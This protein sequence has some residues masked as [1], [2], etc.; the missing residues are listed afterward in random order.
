MTGVEKSKKSL[1]R[2]FQTKA[3][4]VFHGVAELVTDAVPS[5]PR[6]SI[7]NEKISTFDQDANTDPVKRFVDEQ[8]NLKCDA[9]HIHKKFSKK[10]KN[11]KGS[12]SPEFTYTA[13]HNVTNISYSN[14]VHIGPTLNQEF[15]TCDH[16]KVSENHGNEK[17]YRPPVVLTDEIRCLFVD[18]TPCTKDHIL[19]LESHI[20]K[21]WKSLGLSLKFSPGQ[22]EQLATN[23]KQQEEVI[24]QMLLQWT[25]EFTDDAT[26]GT[27]ATALWGCDEKDAV[28]R[29]SQFKFSES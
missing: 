10:K 3:T 8:S 23:Y 26:L 19:H 15:K 28:L 14:N 22:L 5:R 4:A 9:Q 17:D 29:L 18:S 6:S 12:K 13:N 20:G 2:S 11:N 25:Q 24:F 7:D 21:N 27:L 1:F 16:T